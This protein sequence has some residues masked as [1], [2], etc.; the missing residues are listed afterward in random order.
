MSI[1][2]W[3]LAAAI[4]YVAFR[5]VGFILIRRHIQRL[6]Q[7]ALEE[8]AASSILIANVEQVND[9]YYLYNKESNEFLAQGRTLDEISEHFKLRF[10]EKSCVIKES[11]LDSFPELKAAM[12]E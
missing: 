4:G 5:V 1:L 8:R 9:V 10:P 11:T 6:V 7:Q 12:P 3:L 2:Y